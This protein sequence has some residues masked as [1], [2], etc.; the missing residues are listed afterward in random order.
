MPQPKPL[1]T[2]AF[3]IVVA[4]ALS[5]LHVRPAE[6]V[7]GPAAAIEAWPETAG[8]PRLHPDDRRLLLVMIN[9]LPVHL[10][11]TALVGGEVPRIAQLTAERPTVEVT[12]LST[13]PS[14]TFPALPEMLSSTYAE[15]ADPSAPKAVHAFDRQE[16]QIIR[17]FTQPGAWQ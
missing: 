16:R 3:L 4:L 13:F 8:S 12:A 2:A 14:S 15:A 17:Y 5:C 11:K 10:F 9:G 1:P 7:A 6:Q